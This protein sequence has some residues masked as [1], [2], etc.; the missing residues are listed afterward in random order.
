MMKQLYMQKS[1]ESKL[2]WAQFDRKLTLIRAFIR[3]FLSI[4]ITFDKNGD[5][6][7]HI[8]LACSLIT[9]YIIFK[10][11]IDAFFFNTSVQKAVTFYEIASCFLFL[12]LS[13]HSFIDNSNTNGEVTVSITQIF[14]LFIICL[15]LAGLSLLI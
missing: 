13:I 2:P 7:P 15:F 6:K 5:F 3:F 10:R 8:G 14:I 1:I 11:C 12:I 9:S 4:S